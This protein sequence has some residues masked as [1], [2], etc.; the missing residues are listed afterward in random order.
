MYTGIFLFCPLSNRNFCGT[1]AQT[2]KEGVCFMAKKKG[3]FPP[4]A[5]MTIGTLLVSL[6]VY[7]FKFPNNFSFGG[8]TGLAVVAAPYLPI[9]ASDFT[10]IAN[11]LLLL[12]GFVFLGRGFGVKTIYTSLLMSVSLTLLERIFP[13]SAPLTQEPL[14]E[15]GFAIALPAVGAAFLFSVGASGG[16]TDVIAMILKKYT[17][18]GIGQA[19]F[20][21]DLLF[22]LMGGLLFGVETFLFSFAGL[23]IKSLLIDNVIASMNQVKWLQVICSHPEEIC[24]FITEDLK[25]S[26]TLSSGTGA[27]TG[28]ERSI[29][30][31]AMTPRE[32]R[33]LRQFIADADPSAFVM[34]S[35]THEIMG[36][37]F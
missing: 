11:M 14:L 21:S 13:L 36:R 20:F 5:A 37:G 31:T 19:L 12:L 30:F 32:A 2:F 33:R 28:E 22:V 1:M 3:P 29:L 8:V 10:F 24:R 18:I 6:G 34:I 7:F 23:L 4:F 17:S 16:G 25:R 9:S 27:F 35:T 26:A 15:L